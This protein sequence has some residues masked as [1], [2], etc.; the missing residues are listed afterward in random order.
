MRNEISQPKK[1][2]TLFINAGKVNEKKK[3]KRYKAVRSLGI[4]VNN[5]IFTIINRDTFESLWTLLLNQSTY[6]EIL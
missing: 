4:C 1:S 5:M 2:E 3:K 6:G